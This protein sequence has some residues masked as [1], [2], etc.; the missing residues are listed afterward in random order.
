MFSLMVFI[1]GVAVGGSLV[2]MVEMHAVAAERIYKA[3]HRDHRKVPP[4]K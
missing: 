2:A 4:I 3:R 1:I